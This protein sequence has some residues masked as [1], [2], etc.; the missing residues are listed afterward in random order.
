MI[1]NEDGQTSSIQSYASIRRVVLA[2]NLK[3]TKLHI[4]NKINTYEK[5]KL[6]RTRA[7]KTNHSV[8]FVTSFESTHRRN[9]ATRSVSRGPDGAQQSRPRRGAARHPVVTSQS[10][11]GPAA[12]GGGRRVRRR[13]RARR[14]VARSAARTGWTWR[15]LI[16][17]A[18]YPV[19][20]EGPRW[21]SSRSNLA[22]PLPTSIMGPP[23]AQ[24]DTGGTET[25]KET[26]PSWGPKKSPWINILEAAGHRRL[27][28]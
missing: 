15:M 6:Q 17:P 18:G 22:R 27:T 19:F 5:R 24:A 9:L 7:S 11:S 3:S 16:T 12:G 13:R 8:A 23:G 14:P 21:K 25:G 4:V 28:R 2:H 1:N 20:P 10:A 26:P